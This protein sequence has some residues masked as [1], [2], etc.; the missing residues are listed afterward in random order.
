MNKKNILD[1][2]SEDAKSDNQSDLDFI[3]SDWDSYVSIVKNN[4]KFIR[5]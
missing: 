2:F 4:N 1:Y 3:N 5:F